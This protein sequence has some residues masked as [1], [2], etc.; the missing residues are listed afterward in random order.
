MLTKCSNCRSIEMVRNNKAD[1][2]NMEDKNQVVGW[3]CTERGVVAEN[4][5]DEI[6]M[7]YSLLKRY[8]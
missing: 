4:G 2:E 7:Y 3:L 8:L 1:E 6:I 5:N